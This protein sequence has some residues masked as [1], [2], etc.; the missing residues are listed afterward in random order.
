MKPANEL[1]ITARARWNRRIA[2]LISIIGFN[3]MACCCGGMPAA[4]TVKEE[5]GF[6]PS[7]PP[8]DPEKF[9]ERFG[10]P[11]EDNQDEKPEK[12]TR[13]LTYTGQNAKATFDAGDK[14]NPQWSLARIENLKTK[15]VMTNDEFLKIMGDVQRDSE[16]RA[17]LD[18]QA[19]ARR[20]KE[21]EAA[22]LAAAKEKEPAVTRA[23]YHEIKTGMSIPEVEALLG[24][25]KETSR[26]QHHV[27]IVWRSKGHPTTIISITFGSG[28]VKAKSI[29]GP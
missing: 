16:K 15:A 28:G 11:D 6:K 26:T 1:P 13:T 9:I 22:A 24:Y 25:G 8:S 12:T 4:K 10:L 19:E 5:V 23:K 27:N 20:K 18:A 7:T 29:I 14:K 2:L 3:L 17:Y 21:A